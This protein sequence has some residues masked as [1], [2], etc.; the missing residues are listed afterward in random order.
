VLAVVASA[1][2]LTVAVWLVARRSR[3]WLHRVLVVVLAATAGGLVADWEAG[4]RAR[5]RADEEVLALMEAVNAATAEEVEARLAELSRTARSANRHMRALAELT[6]ETRRETERRN[7]SYSEASQKL[8]AATSLDLTTVK[9]ARDL[10]DLIAICRAFTRESAAWAAHHRDV[11]DNFAARLRSLQTSEGAHQ[12]EHRT[13][14][15]EEQHKLVQEIREAEQRWAEA[16]ADRLGMLA[17]TWGSWEAPGGVLVWKDKAAAAR[18]A[19]I[20]ERLQRTSA[21]YH[22]KDARLAVVDVEIPKESPLEARRGFATHVRAAVKPRFVRAPAAAPPPRALLKVRYRSSA[23]DLSAY[24]SPD[25]LDHKVHPAVLWAHGGFEGIGSYLWEPAPAEN[26]QSARAFREAGLVVM[27]PSW[28]GEND[29]PGSFEM[30]YGELDDLLA[31]REYLSSLPYVNSDR[32]YVAGHSVG[33][34]LALLAAAEAGRFRAAFSFGGA[35]DVENT[36]R[37]LSFTPFDLKVEDERRLRSP[38]TF[39]GAIRQPTFYFEGAAAT[40]FASVRRFEALAAKAGVPLDVHVVYGADHF[41]VL[42]PLTRL[43]AHKIAEDKGPSC[44]IHITEDEVRSAFAGTP[45]P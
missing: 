31:A 26:D 34:T 14:A 13:A 10:E 15:A 28:R 2:V 35:P 21:E 22:K 18:Y 43:V 41:S 37:Q 25:P 5:A 8:S 42:A 33:G 24:V 19:T 16:L 32:I 30:F 44:G 11:H 36:A 7:A 20:E 17:E 29:N 27:A 9:E 40:D 39:V 6:V 45:A 38:I 12:L 3:L 23:G 1:G 4:R